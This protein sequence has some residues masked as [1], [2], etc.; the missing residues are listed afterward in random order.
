MQKD[1]QQKMLELFVEF[2]DEQL[3]HQQAT[4]T[5]NPLDAETKRNTDNYDIFSTML[6]ETYGDIA[7]VVAGHHIMAIRKGNPLP[8]EVASADTLI[9]DHYV[10]KKIWKDRYIEVLTKLAQEPI[11]TR[12]TLLRQ[13][14]YSR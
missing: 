2:R 11:E 3:K 5:I 13:L 7:T 4:G 8:I 12:D 6:E 14:F 1:K 9:F 10:A